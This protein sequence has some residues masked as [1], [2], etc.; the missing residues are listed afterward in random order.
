[1]GR[2]IT[3]IKAKKT[4]KRNKSK[5]ENKE[6]SKV[7]REFLNCRKLKQLEKQKEKEQVHKILEEQDTRR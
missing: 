4:E 2:K 5:I 6:F 1:M 3:R 7:N